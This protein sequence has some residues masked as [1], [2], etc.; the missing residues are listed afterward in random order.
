MIKEFINTVEDAALRAMLKWINDEN[1]QRKDDIVKLEE[2]IKVLR[3][4]QTTFE[5]TKKVVEA[6]SNLNKV[7]K[8][9]FVT[10]VVTAIV[11]YI[12]AQIGIG[13]G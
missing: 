13:G 10:A 3:R 2:Q 8:K 12:L 5:D 4:N 11:G 6:Y 1:K 7:I 9:V